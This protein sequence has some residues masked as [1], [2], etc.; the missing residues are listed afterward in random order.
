MRQKRFLRLGRGTAAVAI[1]TSLVGLSGALGTADPAGADGL[2]QGGTFTC[3]ATVASVST[4]VFSV[5]MNASTSGS[6]G[7]AAAATSSGDTITFC[8]LSGVIPS[9]WSVDVSGVPFNLDPSSGNAGTV[10]LGTLGGQASLIGTTFTNQGMLTEDTSGPPETYNL[11]VTDF[12]NTGTITSPTGGYGYV[13]PLDNATASV[14]DNQG[15]IDVTTGSTFTINGSDG[16]T[17][18]NGTAFQQESGAIDVQGTMTVD[19]GSLSFSGGSVTDATTSG[20]GTIT[21]GGDSGHTTVHFDSPYPQGTQGT[22]IFQDSREILDGIIPSGWVVTADSLVVTNAGAGNAG[23]LNVSGFNTLTDPG[24]FSNS[25]T[26]DVTGSGDFH[27]TTPTF[28]NTGT[29]EV[30]QPAL[31]SN[32]EELFFDYDNATTAGTIDNQGTFNLAAN[33]QITIGPTNCTTGEA[34]T[35]E[36]GSS[37]TG[38]GELL[39]QCGSFSINGGSISSAAPVVASPEVHEAISFAS[40]LP[41]GSGGTGDTIH[42]G[43]RG[44]TLSG[45]IPSGWTVSSIANFAAT[46]GAGN[47]GTIDMAGFIVFT[48]PGH[49][50]NSGTFDAAGGGDATVNVADFVN[51]GTVEATGPG[52]GQTDQ[53]LQ[54]TYDNATVAGTID[55]SGTFSTMPGDELDIGTEDC[56][57]G[58]TMTME[59]G[60]SIANAG[61]FVLQCGS[62]TVNGGSITA[63]GPIDVTPIGHETVTFAS[64]LPAGSGGGDTFDVN[65]IGSTFGGDIPAGWTISVQGTTAGLAAGTTNAGTITL[66]GF[67]TLNGAGAFT[68]TGTFDAT[69]GGGTNVSIPAITNSGTVEVTGTTSPTDSESLAFVYDNATTPG[70]IDNLGTFSTMPNQTMIIGSES[71]VKG[72]DFTQEATAT[73]DSGGTLDFQCGALNVNGGTITASGP[74]TLAPI[75]AEAV[76]FVPGLVGTGGNGDNIVLG[77]A[78]TTFHSFIPPGWTILTDGVGMSALPGTGNDGT[79]INRGDQTFTGISDSGMYTNA[80][81]FLETAINSGFVG[82]VTAFLNTGTISLGP[83]TSLKFSTGTVTNSGTIDVAANAEFLAENFV[84]TTGGTTGIGVNGTAGQQGL[85]DVIGSATLG[86]TLDIETAT[87][88]T[89]SQLF[90][91]FTWASNTGQF[92]HVNGAVLGGGLA[93]STAYNATNLRLN[94]VTS[95]VLQSLAASNVAA[96]SNLPAVPGQTLT[97]SYTVTNNGTAAA[98]GGW[99]D[100][101]Y[102]GTGLTY[103]AGDPLL[104]R[105]PIAG[106]LAAGASYTNGISAVVPPVTQ[107]TYHL[108]VVPDSSDLATSMNN[109][110]QAI[111]P[112]FTVGPIPTLT[113]NRLASAELTAGGTVYFQVTV[114]STNDVE[115]QL[116]AIGFPFL[117]NNADDAV[118]YASLGSIPTPQNY[119]VSTSPTS[120]F[121]TLLLPSTSPGVWYIA[122]T[123]GPESV[124]DWGELLVSTS[125]PGLGV[126]NL[127]PVAGSSGPVT[128]TLQGSGF[129]PDL[130]A[131]LSLGF[132]NTATA[133]SVQV[134]SSTTAFATFD[135]SGLTPEPYNLDVFSGGHEVG[136]QDAFT[137]EPPGA[138]QLQVSSSG[139]G[140]LRFGFFGTAVITMTNTGTSNI[141]IPI[142][143]VSAQQNAQIDVPG[144]S[145]GF[146]QSV[147]VVNPQ[148][149]ATAGGPP[150]QP[151]VLPPGVTAT[152]TYV[153]AAEDLFGQP[154]VTGQIFLVDSAENTPIDWS[155]QLASDQPATMSPT[156]WNTVVNDVAN[157]LGPTEGTYATA[158]SSIISEAAA[159]GV[160]FVSEGQALA[161]IVQQQIDSGAGA[162]VTGTLYF[163]SLSNV[164]PRTGI[165]LVSAD[166]TQTLTGTSW[167]DGKFS[168]W[169]VP[170]GTYNLMVT[171]FL[172]RV[173]A[174]FN[175]A[176]AAN[177]LAVVVAPGATLQ[178]TITDSTASAPVSGAVVTVTDGSGTVVGQPSGSDG[179]YSVPGLV[180]G[181]VTVTVTG[182]DILSSTVSTTVSLAAPTTQNFSL[183]EGGKITGT[184]TALHGGPPPTGT[185]V[186]ATPDDG[187]GPA[188]VGTVNSDGTFSIGG[189]LPEA[190]PSPHTY[191][192]VAAAPGT[193]GASQD[194]VT[195]TGTSTTS[196]IALS[197][198]DTSTVSGTVVDQDS[199]QQIGGVTVSTDDAS[200][201][202][203]TTTAPNGTYTLSGVATGTQNLTFTPTDGGHAAGTVAV[204]PTGGQVLTEDESLAP[205]GTATITVQDSGANALAGQTVQLVGPVA[206]GA[207]NATSTQNAVSGGDGTATFEDLSPG[208]YDA[209]VPGSFQQAALTVGPGSRQ[210]TATIT[211]AVATVSGTVTDSS[212]N[213]LGSVAIAASD[214]TGPIV[215]TATAADGTYTLLLTAAG[216]YS[217]SAVGSAFGAATQPVTAALDNTSTANFQAGTAS[218][219]VSVTATSNPVNG[220]TVELTAGSG[221]TTTAPIVLQTDASGSV[222]F[223]PLATGSYTVSAFATGDAISTQTVPVGAGAN[224]ATFPLG[225]EG[226]IDGTVSDGGGPVSGASVVATATSGSVRQGGHHRQR[227]YL[228]H[229]QSAG[230]DVQRLH[231]RQHRCARDRPGS[232]GGARHAQHGQPDAGRRRQHG[233][234]GR[235]G[236]D[237]RDLPI[238]FGR[239]ARRQ[240]RGHRDRSPRSRP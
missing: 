26:F 167:Y 77:R 73:I 196:G 137:V 185:T 123:G 76:T 85:V 53:Q 234:A 72:E 86:G 36:S 226:V 136:L 78:G 37:I 161:W 17:C 145:N 206:G 34:L 236:R 104:E 47:A 240:W 75:S 66:N 189:L 2:T 149:T 224:T 59:S 147:D 103:T 178:G 233:D 239:R 152:Y 193:G 121:P 162:S 100:S 79:I 22:L 175:V 9:G 201:P 184:I 126:N 165:T 6:T 205:L 154:Q 87:A 116:S 186:S 192:V 232:R 89:V 230:R 160:T 56:S 166:G 128:I 135:L 107:G 168:F 143:R 181:P 29:V 23:T 61:T 28:S 176:P 119:M 211:I 60:S 120:S 90:Q 8:T 109:D 97:S 84:Q 11:K 210:P 219:A 127:S 55:N 24:S 156:S 174:T 208:T 74:I 112:D 1:V 221:A 179:T 88:P 46:D 142:L 19:C 70:T 14:F 191:D 44:V 106:P 204:D 65:R 238:P 217:V 153:I 63:A 62:F 180:A 38:A 111:S 5:T 95:S 4:Q 170:P 114:P 18:T 67:S 25:G 52:T 227:R 214:P 133:T 124:G 57:T 220:A 229:R 64:G 146:T 195:V 172:P 40:G 223:S 115:I 163:T 207:A 139:G 27:V 158:L 216:S 190:G 105:L 169:D 68:N 98:T 177:G 182:P 96:P 41:A 183:G 49:F 218:L 188:V 3:T 141:D 102:L 203:S 117:V 202:I 198:L 16:S 159:D 231:L 81:T 237:G 225:P 99:E 131:T 125:L 222:S 150:L 50:T 13:L 235:T 110:Q 92:P 83:A 33:Q 171:G 10:S 35:S 194:G 20:S 213:P 54:F 82:L 118:A 80:G 215:S 173:A 108:I 71:C 132:V 157:E 140:S 134:V 94:V 39:L 187:S 32:A 93:Y 199:G 43:A 148:L 200:T 31:S 101:V 129:G 21:V 45:T 48:D 209:Q 7:S 228:P 130:T 58:E 151:G 122:I 91:I 197:L 144:I 138:P 12:T 51:T 69:G 113:P 30:T 15:T 212:G 164:L 155:S 42:I